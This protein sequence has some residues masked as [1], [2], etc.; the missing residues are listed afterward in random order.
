M[1][2]GMIREN[3]RRAIEKSIAAD[4]GLAG[5]AAAVARGL[6]DD[7]GHPIQA[8]GAN[9]CGRLSPAREN[10]R[11]YLTATLQWSARDAALLVEYASLEFAS[12]ENWPDH[13]GRLAPPRDRWDRSFLMYPEFPGETIDALDELKLANLG[14]LAAIGEQKATQLLAQLASRFDKDAGARYEALFA[15]WGGDVRER[16][17]RYG[18]RR[19]SPPRTGPSHTWS[20]PAEIERPGFGCR[21]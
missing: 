14:P 7:P 1:I 20:G 4:R 12:L 8:A 10:L 3:A 15:A 19:H 9:A 5:R 13:G 2:Y 18:Q 21:P 11:N 16:L 6:D 17:D